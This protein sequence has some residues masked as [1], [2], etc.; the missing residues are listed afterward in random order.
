[1][2]KHW[3]ASMTRL[4]INQILRDRLGKPGVHQY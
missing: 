4:G 2:R 3:A 1:M